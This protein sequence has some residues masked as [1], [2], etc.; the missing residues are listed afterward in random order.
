MTTWHIRSKFT[1]SSSP[2]ISII[3]TWNASEEEAEKFYTPL[4]N[5]SLTHTHTHC[6][7]VTISPPLGVVLGNSRSA[8][9]VTNLS[10]DPERFSNVSYRSV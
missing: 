2:S 10:I 5:N 3:A 1:T 4:Q 9:Y 6:Q 8:R 7:G